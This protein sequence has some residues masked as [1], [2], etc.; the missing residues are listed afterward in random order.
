MT[1]QNFLN[2]VCGSS[3]VEG[4]LRYDPNDAKARVTVLGWL[5]LVLK[6]LA[7][8]QQNFHWRF[9]EKQA[10]FNTAASDFDY[11]LATIAV[12]IDTTKFVNVYDK[13]DDNTYIYK[14]YEEFRKLIADETISTGSRFWYSIFAGNL[15]LWPLPAGIVSTS[16]DYVRVFTD[17]TDA[18]T[19]IDVPSKYDPVLVDGVLVYAQ[20]FDPKRVNPAINFQSKYE[21]GVRRM[22]QD[23]SMI[24]DDMPRLGSHRSRQPMEPGLDRTSGVY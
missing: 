17:A 19:A 4:L 7:N 23:N 22:I 11:A 9:L 8:R 6:D 14:P 16:I 18:A 20:M 1:G 10:T 2:V 5:N 13:T 21:D 12:D 24:I 15:L 3:T